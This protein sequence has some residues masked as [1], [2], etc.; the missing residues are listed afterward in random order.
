MSNK[1][2]QYSNVKAGDSKLLSLLS[3]LKPNT[4][5]IHLSA[6]RQSSNKR[7]GTASTKTK[8]E[9]RGGGAK[10]WTQKGTGRARAGSSRSPLWVGGGIIFG[11][12][13]RSFKFDIPQKARNVALGHALALKKDNIVVL[14]AIPEIK[15]GK[16]KNL[17]KE[18]TAMNLTNFPALIIVSQD[19]AN[20]ELLERSARNLP[21]VTVMNV[22]YMGMNEIMNAGTLMISEAALSILEKRFVGLLKKGKAK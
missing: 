8:G 2:T 4:H 6:L 21:N 1:S 13:P 10:P 3:D 19:E 7:A 12:K 5:L 18:L 11:P 16:T 22:H 14:K 17:Q 15:D 9:V 20:Y